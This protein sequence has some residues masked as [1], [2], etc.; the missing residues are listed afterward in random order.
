MLL[1]QDWGRIPCCTCGLT[2][3]AHL[4]V[5]CQNFA[6]PKYVTAI[7]STLGNLMDTKQALTLCN[8]KLNYH[9]YFLVKRKFQGLIHQS[10]LLTRD[11][12]NQKQVSNG[13]QMVRDKAAERS[14]DLSLLFLLM[15][16]QDKSSQKEFYCITDLPGRKQYKTTRLLLLS[17]NNLGIRASWDC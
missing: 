17:Q 5:L 12:C 4:S 1:Q 16:P 6:E 14:N 3:G 13:S 9:M 10:K 15:Y 11:P 7:P 2:P 8:L